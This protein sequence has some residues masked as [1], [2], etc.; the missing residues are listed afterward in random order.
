[1]NINTI[2]EN[3]LNVVRKEK[4]PVTIFLV[5][6]FQVRGNISAFD[7]FIIIVMADGKQQMIYKHAVSTI[8]PAKLVS[9]AASE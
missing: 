6:G 4:I 9:L 5:N 1:M 2:Q 7:N 8:I 3:F